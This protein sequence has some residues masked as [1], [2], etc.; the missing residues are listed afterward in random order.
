MQNHHLPAISPVVRQLWLALAF[1]VLVVAVGLGMNQTEIPARLGLPHVNLPN[2]RGD[3]AQTEEAARLAA[4]SPSRSEEDEA[5]ELAKSELAVKSS[6]KPTLVRAVVSR[7]SVDRQLA[8]T[9][10]SHAYTEA[11]SSGLPVTLLLGVMARESSF[12]PK[13]IN[14]RDLGLMQVNLKWHADA[15][16]KAGGFNAML[17]PAPNIKV[18]TKILQQ[19]VAAAGSIRGGLRQYNGK[20]KNNAYPEEVLK[21]KHE[22]DAAL[23]V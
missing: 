11:R 14:N 23:R 15:I 13:A 19:Y 4:N 8:H 21:F 22:F 20:G 9:I 18:G 2:F 3:V 16:Q 5:A 10:V 6:A 17:R 7:F 12:K 1:M